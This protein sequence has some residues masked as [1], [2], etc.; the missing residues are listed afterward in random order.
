MQARWCHRRNALLYIR[1]QALD[2][3]RLVLQLNEDGVVTQVLS[4]TPASLFEC[5]PV[6]LVGQ[7]ACT[8]LDVLRPEGE[9]GRRHTNV[10]LA[11]HNTPLVLRRITLTGNRQSTGNTAPAACGVASKL[12]GAEQDAKMDIICQAQALDVSLPNAVAQSLKAGSCDLLELKSTRAELLSD[13]H[14]HV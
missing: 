5:D 10:M 2:E 11:A 7:H 6:K 4:Q 1:L 8:F 9:P 14:A 13:T 3:R 12:A